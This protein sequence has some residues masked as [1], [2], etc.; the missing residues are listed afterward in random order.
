M[1]EPSK[2]PACFPS[3]SPH[4][5]GKGNRPAV[6]HSLTIPLPLPCVSQRAPSSFPPFSST[7]STDVLASHWLPGVSHCPLSSQGTYFRIQPT[8][9]EEWTCIGWRAVL[10]H[11][12]SKSPSV[13]RLR[14]ARASSKTSASTASLTSLPFCIPSCMLK[15]T[16]LHWVPLPLSMLAWSSWFPFAISKLT[17]MLW[18][19][20]LI[21]KVA[22]LS[23][24]PLPISQLTSSSWRPLLVSGFLLGRG[25]SECRDC[26]RG[27]PIRA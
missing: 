9:R 24:C 27:G 18:F 19:T 8:S 11:T 10:I 7:L 23:W 25:F 21:S 5:W 6:E 16:C 2:A 4:I 15:L 3:S 17:F 13:P 22:S 26:N 20:F 1:K 12:N 14:N